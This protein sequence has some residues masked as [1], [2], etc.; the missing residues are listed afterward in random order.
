LDSY[1][2]RSTWTAPDDVRIVDLMPHMH[3]RV[4]PDGM[5]EVLLSVLR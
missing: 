1:E 5:Q 2:V 4:Y 3:V